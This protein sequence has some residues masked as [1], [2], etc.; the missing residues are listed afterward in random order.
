VVVVSLRVVVGRLRVC[1][2]VGVGLGPVPRVAIRTAA[3]MT[4]AATAVPTMIQRRR[5]RRGSGG[6]PGAVGISAAG[7][8]TLP[9]VGQGSAG[10]VPVRAWRAAVASCVAVW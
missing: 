7:P 8:G 9:G 1:V 2:A 5:E 3:V 4:A 6:Q 10:S